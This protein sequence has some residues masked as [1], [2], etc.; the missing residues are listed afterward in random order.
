MDAGEVELG[1][2]GRRNRDSRGRGEDSD[3]ERNRRQALI[4][5]HTHSSRPHAGLPEAS[6]PPPYLFPPRSRPQ[7]RTRARVLSLQC[8]LSACVSGLRF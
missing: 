4:S 3:T 7:I 6:T 5:P 2:W 1:A 8:P